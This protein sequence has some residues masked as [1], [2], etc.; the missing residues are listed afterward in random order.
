[1]TCN[2]SHVLEVVLDVAPTLLGSSRAFTMSVL[3]C[4]DLTPTSSGQNA[5]RIDLE[6][7]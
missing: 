3:S 1:M 2:L 6:L 4:D 7:G 5:G